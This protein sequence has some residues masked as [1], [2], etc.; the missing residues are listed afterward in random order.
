M[1]RTQFAMFVT[2]YEMELYFE[3]PECE[4]KIRVNG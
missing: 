2:T 4:A 3:K 1:L